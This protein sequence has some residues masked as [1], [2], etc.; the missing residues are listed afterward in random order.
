MPPRAP[1]SFRGMHHWRDYAK[2]RH[3]LGRSEVGKKERK[4]SNAV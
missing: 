4:P 1:F 3:A 2:V